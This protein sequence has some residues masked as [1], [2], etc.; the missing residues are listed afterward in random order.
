MPSIKRTKGRRLN[1]RASLLI[2]SSLVLIGAVRFITD[3]LHERDPDYWMSLAGSWLRYVVR[4]PTDGTLLGAINAQWFKL[5]AIPS[6]ISLIYLRDRFAP[7]TPAS[8]EAAFHD[9]AVRGVW[10][11]VFWLGFTVIEIEKQLSPFSMGVHLVEGE[12]PL[13]NH[14]AHIIGAVL[15]WKLAGALS[16]TDR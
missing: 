1:P 13:I 7:G 9:W 15:A 8:N 14:I 4:A 2:A 12:D 10:I 5:L 11:A 3:V 6:G 16:M